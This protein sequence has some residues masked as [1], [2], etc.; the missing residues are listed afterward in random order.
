MGE[1]IHTNHK[2]ISV[3]IITKNEEDMIANAIAGTSFADEVIV[4]DSGSSDNTVEIATR[5]G[6]KVISVSGGNFADWRNRGLKEASGDWILYIDSDERVTPK[7]VREIKDT[8]KITSN[9]S[10]ALRRNNIH[11]GKWLQ[12]GGWNQDL[13]VRLFARHAL[14]RWEGKVHEHALVEGIAGELKEPLIHLTHRNLVDG[15]KKTMVWTQI[16]AQLLFE[17]KVPPVRV[18]TLLRKTG[19][20]F[21][22][23]LIFKRGYKD[24]IEGWIEC[25][26]QAMNR[27]IVYERLWELQ[28]KPSLVDSYTRLEKEIIKLWEK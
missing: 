18:S 1:S 17:A 24:G 15:L 13:L 22:R 8:I 16:E 12:H 26:Q 28:R 2:S 4:V 7:L 10:Y 27:F 14:I 6:A 3:V 9:T 11:F 20:E 5:E 19:M 25:M 21:I 23:R